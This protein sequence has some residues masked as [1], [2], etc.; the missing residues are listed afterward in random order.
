MSEKKMFTVFIEAIHQEML[1]WTPK[2]RFV[3]KDFWY[4]LGTKGVEH[5]VQTQHLEKEKEGLEAQILIEI[6]E[7]VEKVLVEKKKK[8]I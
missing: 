8:T 7:G 4:A 2:P 3:F 6:E 1:A 5:V